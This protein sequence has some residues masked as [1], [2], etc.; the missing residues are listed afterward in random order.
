MQDI[1]E[2]DGGAPTNVA[3]GGQIDGIGVGAK[4]EPGVPKKRMKKLILGY[5]RRKIHGTDRKRA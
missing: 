4:G 5:I 3:G 2:E 1:K